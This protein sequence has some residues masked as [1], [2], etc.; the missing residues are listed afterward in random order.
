MKILTVGDAHRLAELHA[1]LPEDSKIESLGYN[2]LIRRDLSGYDIIFDLNLDD[3]PDNL[4]FYAALDHVIV[5]GSAVKKSLVEMKRYAPEAIL[6]TLVGINALNGF[7]GRSLK[8]LSLYN[9][10]DRS[11]LENILRYL[12]WEGRIV[13]DRVGLVTPR[14]I[15]MI[16]NE[17]YFTLQ[18]G[19]ASMEDIDMGMK[20]G[21]NYPKG[22]FEWA[23][24]IGYKDVYETLEALYQ[25]MHDERYKICPRLKSDYLMLEEV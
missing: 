3:Y 19:T 12:G 13:A 22:P 21:T 18:E 11:R 7:L 4:S 16:I 20:L 17:A 5:I 1:A 9:M 10:E 25:D 23:A 2:E 8:E 15:C 24:E 14:V 6:C